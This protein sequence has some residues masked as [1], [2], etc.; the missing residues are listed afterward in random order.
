MEA[1]KMLADVQ[2]ALQQDAFPQSADE[3]I[4]HVLQHTQHRN[5]GMRFLQTE[6]TCK[7]CSATSMGGISINHF[8]LHSCPAKDDIHATHS[9]SALCTINPHCLKR[10]KHDH[11]SVCQQHWGGVSAVKDCLPQKGAGERAF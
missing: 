4:A 5:T 8:P 1:D 10:L 6:H 11:R 9:T 2:A 7:V 3:F